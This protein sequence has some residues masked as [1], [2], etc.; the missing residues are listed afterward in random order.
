[1]NKKL[2]VAPQTL[3]FQVSAEGM[4]ATSTIKMDDS[5]SGTQQL[6]DGMEDP[7]SNESWSEE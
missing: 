5:I 4:M 6:S 2:Y 1:M 7:W 3:T